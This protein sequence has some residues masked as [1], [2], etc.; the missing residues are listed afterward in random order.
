MKPL[1]WTSTSTMMTPCLTFIHSQTTYRTT[2][3]SLPV[4]LI[5]TLILRAGGN[6]DVGNIHCH[7]LPGSHSQIASHRPPLAKT[8]FRTHFS[9]PTEIEKHLISNLIGETSRIPLLNLKKT[10]TPTR[11]G[12]QYRESRAYPVLHPM[13]APNK[14]LLSWGP[15]HDEHTGKAKQYKASLV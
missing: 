2:L 5:G 6:I 3:L 1:C 11:A 15:P 4:L 8:L 12:L 7:H 9:S 10:S 13:G 14:F